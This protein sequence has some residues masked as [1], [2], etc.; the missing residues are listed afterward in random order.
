MSKFFHKLLG[1]AAGS[2]GKRERERQEQRARLERLPDAELTSGDVVYRQTAHHGMPT[3]STSVVYDDAPAMIVH[4]PDVGAGDGVGG[5]GDGDGGD[6]DGGDGDVA[7][8]VADAQIVHPAYV[9]EPSAYHDRVLPAL[10]STLLGPTP[11]VR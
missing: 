10:I 5:G 1:K 2:E 6:V 7:A 4:Q 8:G 11:L 3:L 9:T